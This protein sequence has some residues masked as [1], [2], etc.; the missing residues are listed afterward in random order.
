MVAKPKRDLGGRVVVDDE[1]YE[2]RL[3]REPQ[4]CSNDGWKGLALTV[5][6]EDGQR[7][8]VLQFPMPKPFSNGAPRA[9]RPRLS[10]ALVEQGVRDALACGWKPHSRGKMVVVELD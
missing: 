9:E 6:H 2:W 7:E 4:W 5:R 10:P 1:A 8:A 3:L